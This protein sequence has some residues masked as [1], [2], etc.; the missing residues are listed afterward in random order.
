MFLQCYKS[1]TYVFMFFNVYKSYKSCY[2]IKNHV[3]KHK[4]HVIKH[5]KSCHKT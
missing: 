2:N 1:Y 3:I 4:N 5:K